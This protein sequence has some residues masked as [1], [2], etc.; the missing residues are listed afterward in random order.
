[1]NGIPPDQ[2]P[3]AQ[4]GA[5]PG[6]PPYW[7]WQKIVGGFIKPGSALTILAVLAIF[8]TLYFAR[9][10]LTPLAV[11]LVVSFVFMPVLRVARRTGMPDPLSAG[12]IVLGLVTLLGGSVYLLSTPVVDW[13]DRLPRV[14]REIERKVD[15]VRK[16]VDQVRKASEQMEEMGRA[17]S[18]E[19]P[20]TEVVVRQES[21]FTRMITPLGRIGASVLVFFVFL[22]FAL[23]SSQMFGDKIV[24]VAPRIADKARARK[25]M[26]DIERE[27]STYLF[28]ITLV[29][30]G[31]GV[32]IG[33]GMWAIG[34]PNPLLWGVLA[35]L[36][37]FIPYFGA[38]AG[39][40]MTGV[41]AL[42]AFD[43]LFAA[44][45]APLWYFSMNVIE[46]QFITPSVL[47]RRH[48][49]NPVVV[50]LAIIFWGWLWGVVGA[51]VAVPFLVMFK[52]VCAHVDKLKILDELLGGRGD[53]KLALP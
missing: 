31:L 28:S 53:K 35:G 3:V 7:A 17:A 22:F 36:L 1:M 27:I 51:F 29:N 41:A 5:G 42:L 26:H 52:A 19:K 9:E 15:Q 12:L 30:I 34:L 43:T 40:L 46:S 18:G 45:L 6:E 32:G 23:A 2:M 11:G 10:M 47:G 48:T 21:R 20:A 8:Y 16:P 25:I 4:S 39:L 38:L 50:F 24:R 37:N 13:I 14:A 33:L 49:L 44:A